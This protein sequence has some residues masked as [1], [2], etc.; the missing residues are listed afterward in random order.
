[1]P[2]ELSFWYQVENW[3]PAAGKQYAQAVVM[4]HDKGLLATIG[5]ETLQIRY[6]LAGLDGPPYEKVRNARYLMAGSREPPQE[7]WLRF[8]TNVKEDFLKVWDFSPK[9]FDKIEFFFEVRY[10]DPIPP[11]QSA[12]ADVYWDDFFLS[13]E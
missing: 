11:G 7:G 13:R 5:E 6:I 10:D 8:R 3:R 12:D 1:M 4:V 9:S 2:G